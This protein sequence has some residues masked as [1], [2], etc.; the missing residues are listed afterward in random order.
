[1]R[2]ALSLLDQA[3]SFGGKRVTGEDLMA[4]LGSVP[5]ELLRGVVG[6]VLEQDGAQALRALTAVQDRGCDIRQF[7]GELV[8]HVRNVLV[9]KVVTKPDDLIELAP[10]EQAEVKADAARLTLDHVQELLRIFLQAEEGLRISQ[11]PWFALELAVVRACRVSGERAVTPAA[12]PESA[13]GAP[14][15]QK[16]RMPEPASQSDRKT[17]GDPPQPQGGSQPPTGA[18]SAALDWEG[19]VARICGERPNLGACL[20]EAALVGMEGSVVTIGFPSSAGFSMQRVQQ[21]EYKKAIV[22]TCHALSGLNVRLRVVALD[23]GAA[24][25]TIAQLRRAR[26]AETERHLREEALA[27]PLVKEALSVF[28]GELKEVRRAGHDKA[29][30][31][32]SSE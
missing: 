11:H 13:R 23:S 10:E 26:E 7:C 8:E 9:A 15:A 29:G 18:V 20:E 3:V 30:T 22:E 17:P 4:L 31:A 24:L 27:N 32:G 2:D 12:R 16:S 14:P 5:R 25:P 28:G 6:A 1:M 21:E 19:V